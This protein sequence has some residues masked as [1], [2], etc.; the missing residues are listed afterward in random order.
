MAALAF[1]NSHKLRQASE[2]D[3]VFASPDYRVSGPACLLLAKR[4]GAGVNRLG[5]VV[6]KKKVPSAVRR[7][8]IKR[9]IREAFR[10]ST[11]RAQSLDMV[12]L[13]RPRAAE[14]TKPELATTMKQMFAK[15]LDRAGDTHAPK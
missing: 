9:L 13:V 6:G 10:T 3:L 5:M 11:N 8:Q 1:T 4:R 12:V 15:L 14:M 7:N 2:F